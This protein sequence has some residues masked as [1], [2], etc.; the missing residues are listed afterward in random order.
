VRRDRHD[1]DWAAVAGRCAR[2]GQ[3][4]AGA[5]VFTGGIGEHNS[6]I[7]A[8]AVAGLG[9]LGIS[10]DTTRSPATTDAVM[11]T[12]DAL[13]RPWP[14]PPGEDIEIARQAREVLKQVT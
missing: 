6:A 14:S 5:I 1:R 2:A 4:L 8:A 3:V 10:V 9:F 7:L 13:C 12:A 11:S